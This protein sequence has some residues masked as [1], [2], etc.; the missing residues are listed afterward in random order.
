MFRHIVGRIISKPKIRWQAICFILLAGLLVLGAC[1]PA[2]TPQTIVQTVVV[3]KEVQ[4]ETVKVI[5]TVEV[6]K[7]V[8]VTAA[9]AAAPTQAKP[10]PPSSETDTIPIITFGQGF[11][12]PELFG[13]DGVTE[14]DRLKEFEKQENVDV[15]VE[16]GDETAVRQKVAADLASRTGRYC[17]MVAG[18]DGGVQTYG[19]GGLLEPLDNYFTWF[20]Q[21]YLDVED[22]YPSFMEANRMNG[23]L[24]ALPYYSFGPGMIYRK[25][26]FE[27]YSLTPPKTI[28]ELNQVLEKLKQGL[29]A[30]GMKDV[31]PITMRGAPGEEPSLDLLGFVYAYAGYPAW[32][33]GGPITAEEITAKKA[34]PIFTSKDFAQ[35]F[36]TYA[37]I[38]KKY[39]PPGAAT[40]TWVDMMTLYQQEKAV[41]LMPSAINGYGAITFAEDKTLKDKSAFAPSPVGP[42]GKP[43][44][45]F[46]TFSLGI[47]AD[48]PA[49]AKAWKVLTF[50][51]GKESQQA[52]ADRVG[53][54][55]VTMKSVMHSKSLVDRW[56]EEE[57]Q[58]NEDAI[59]NSDPHYFPYIPEL[60]EYMDRIGT[61]VSD[62]ISEKQTS[63]Q[64]LGQLESW[65]TE[66]MLRAG[67]YR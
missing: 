41:I 35:G 7:E 13:D 50:L 31:Y 45:S 60:N 46:W 12:W 14:S 24:Y 62:V 5:E 8:V 36:T 25:D 66:R 11:A 48:C 23:Q 67:Y 47:N 29:E 28:D 43:I 21:N 42:S 17:L 1:G 53:W 58:A 56:G 63:E 10:E 64:A 59:L 32:F 9:P 26:L 20:P 44:Q 22:V 33:E 38:L 6:T 18:S 65:A 49:K 19:A 37:D 4:G 51:T 61:A 27:K 30:D 39:G 2:P 52:F 55:T 3:T 40:H 54:P 34:Q 57:I 16:W 15:V